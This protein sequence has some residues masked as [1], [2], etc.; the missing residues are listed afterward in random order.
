MLGPVLVPLHTLSHLI[1]TLSLSNR[2]YSSHGADQETEVQRDQIARAV[3]LEF[4]L[5]LDI[6]RGPP[7]RSIPTPAPQP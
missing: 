7:A 6:S 1:L 2:Y 5:G 4:K 3:K